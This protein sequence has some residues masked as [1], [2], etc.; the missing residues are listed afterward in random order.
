MKLSSFSIG[1]PYEP[2]A[3]MMVS[4]FITLLAIAFILITFYCCFS[5]TQS[6]KKKTAISDLST[7]ELSKVDVKEMRN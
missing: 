5:M 6:S 4:A 7:I 2:L 3:T 1:Q